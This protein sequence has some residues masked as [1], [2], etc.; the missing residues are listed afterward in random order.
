MGTLRVWNRRGQ[1]RKVQFRAKS[2]VRFAVRSEETVVEISDAGAAGKI[3]T[4]AA[5]AEVTSWV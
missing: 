3:Q 4:T 1:I 5:G 2:G